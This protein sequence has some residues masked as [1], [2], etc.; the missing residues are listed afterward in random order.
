M[1]M[2]IIRAYHW[3][4]A[5]IGGY[6][7]LPCPVCGENFGGHELGMT[8]EGWAVSVPRG[9]NGGV[10]VCSKTSC[11][12]FAYLKTLEQMEKGGR[13]PV[14]YSALAPEEVRRKLSKARG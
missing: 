11:V 3:L 2:K 10:C 14:Y 7:W 5:A 1:S 13:Q 6:F 8:P 12:K 4:R 9:P